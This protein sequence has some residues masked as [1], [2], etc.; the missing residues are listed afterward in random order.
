MRKG[1]SFARVLLCSTA[2]F[3]ASRAIKDQLLPFEQCSAETWWM[4]LFANLSK[5]MLL[6]NER[7]SWH[8]S[9]IIAHN[10][11]IWK[12]IFKILLSDIWYFPLSKTIYF[13]SKAKMRRP[14]LI[15]F[16]SDS[17]F[18]NFSACFLLLLKRILK[19]P[20]DAS[21]SLFPFVA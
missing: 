4:T 6:T 17:Q 7:K 15:Y 8:K 1:D 19:I 2:I 5:K 18:V 21:W 3:H 10:G 13:V 11:L 12:C 14:I 9:V 20:F 16:C